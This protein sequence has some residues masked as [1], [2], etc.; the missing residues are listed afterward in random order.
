M[1]MN[2]KMIKT[3]DDYQQALDR[4]E[5]IFDAP[6]NSEEGDEAEILSILIEKYEEVHYPIEPQ[7][8]IKRIE[9]NEP[10]D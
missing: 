3:E 8:P 7:A 4:L 2:I 10:I 1:T 9:K 5:V 6:I